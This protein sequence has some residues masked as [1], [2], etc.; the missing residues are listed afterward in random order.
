V[1]FALNVAVLI[2]SVA[3][4]ALE[5]DA[6]YVGMRVKDAL[7]VTAVEGAMA[8]LARWPLEDDFFLAA[9]RGYDNCNQ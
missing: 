9:R 2:A 1:G 8:D 3:V 6:V 7:G 4:H 5:V